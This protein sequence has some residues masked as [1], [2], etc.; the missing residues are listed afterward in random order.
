MHRGRAF[1]DVG[2]G[3][4]LQVGLAHHYSAGTVPIYAFEPFPDDYADLIEHCQALGGPE[5]P[6]CLPYGL[7][8]GEHR[9]QM[10]ISPRHLG[11]HI[12][13]SLTPGARVVINIKAADHLPIPQPFLVKID[14]GGY[15]AEVLTGMRLVIEQSEPVIVVK[16][17]PTNG[18]TVKTICSL[19]PD[20]YRM[21]FIQANPGKIER[22]TRSTGTQFPW[23][24]RQEFS[25]SL[26]ELDCNFNVNPLGEPNVFG[27][28]SQHL[29]RF[30]E[31]IGL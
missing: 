6:L 18:L 16:V 15:E 24:H 23:F 5:V 22:I 1:W 12:T 11:S 13:D 9:A 2:A 21:F 17:N 28:K 20:D 7:G 3:W 4:G 19:L 26:Q 14:T 29:A 25:F 30:S 27:I 8:S 31:L 10:V